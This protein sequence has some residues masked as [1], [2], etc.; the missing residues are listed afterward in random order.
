MWEGHAAERDAQVGQVREVGPGGFAGL[1]DRGWMR[2][3]R[4]RPSRPGSSSLIGS[5]STDP[6]TRRRPF[7]CAALEVLALVAYRQPIA[8]S[9]IEHVRG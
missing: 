4:R 2:T 7:S 9:G 5:R 8:R 3:C 6:Q 1:I